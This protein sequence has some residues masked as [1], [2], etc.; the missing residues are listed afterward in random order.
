VLA[1]RILGPFEVVDQERPVRLGG[2]K[3][4]AL[5]AI[6]LLRRGEAVPSDRLIDQLWGERPPA[7]AAKTLQGY[8]SHLRK[9]LG[10][11][12]L[13][14]RG[15]GYLLV[16][17]PGQVD[18][19]CFEAM[20]TDAR[21]ALADGDAAGARELLD[22]ALGLWRG[23]PLA[24]LAYEPFAQGEVARLKEARLAALEDR[25]DSDL[26]LGD[27]RTLVGE[28]EG[29]VRLHPYRER[30]RGQLMLALYR[31]GRQ[32]DALDTY[33]RGRQALSHDLGLEPG[34]EL[35]A[36]EQRILIHDT[37]LETPTAT[38][39]GRRSTERARGGRGR[40]LIAA[41]GALLVAAAVAAGIVELTHG[42]GIGLR[43]VANSLAA[44]D[45]HSDR[46]T[47]AVPV[48][49]RPGAV[50]FGSGSL[51]VA[52][53]DDQ[54]VSRIDPLTLRTLRTIP[55]V[56]PPT[57][58]AASAGGV[59]VVESNLNP[60][61]SPGTSSVLVGRVEPEFNTLG[62]PVQIGNVVPSGPGA[63]AAQGNSVWVAPST[64]LLTHLNA[65]TGEVGPQLNPNASPAGIALGDG[66]IWLTDTEAN[67][68]VRVDS[69]GLPTPIAV[70]NAP[71]GI[72]VGAGGVWVVDSLDDKVVR[73]DPG[74]RSV[75]AMIAVGRSPAGVA[76][77]AGSVWVAN[78]GDGTVTRINPSTDKAIA[79]IA[80][81]GSPQAVTIA[82]GK[83]W[84]AVDAQSIAPT[85]VGS[86]G[87]TLRIV[88][89]A[90]VD[91]MDPALAAAPLSDQL[92]YATC[93]QL[94]NYPD[95]AGLAGSQL[96][97]EVAQSLP[98]PSAGGR[99]YTFR[100]RRGF[101]FSPPS[102]QPVTAQTFKD[103]I[104]RTLNPGMHSPWAHFLAD[105]VGARAYMAG[106]ASH[107]TGVVANRDTLTI[108]LL[109]PAPDFLS[110]LALPAFCAVPSN[111]PIN[112]NGVRVIPSAGP[113]YVTS[114]TPGQGVV[115]MRNPN[116][117]GSRPHHFARIELAVGISTQRAVAEIEAGSADYTALGLVSP[118]STTITTLA[119]QLAAR[120]GPGSAAATRGGQRYFVDPS[121]QLD[122][123]VLNTHRPLFSDVRMRQAVN[124]AINRR[125]LAQRGDYFQPLPERPAD[126]YLP[127]G[128]PGYR[129]AHIYPTTPDVAK[130]RELAG[131]GGRTAVLYTC[132]VSPCPE[133]AEIVKK[134]L[135][136][137]GLQVQVK[138]FPSDTLF[139]RE[140]TP[141]EPFDLAW[142][143]WIPDYLDPQAM[144]TSILEDSSVGPTFDDR[145]Y[146]RKLTRAARLSGPER[147]LTY[148]KLDLDLARNAA[149]LAA[150]GNLP[151]NDFFSARIGC[152]TYGIDGMDLA[153]LCL[154]DPRR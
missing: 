132:N 143:G 68:V 42:G 133:Q 110:R 113:Y 96:T 23:E 72:T 154:R 98:A 40:A 100:V 48:G 33:R 142:E 82:G 129:D 5:L 152:Q 71:T 124:Y 140:A 53:L 9:A 104:E 50:A 106:K 15:G 34:P 139:A 21:H 114:Y 85:H 13:L 56:G 66:A 24:D 83:A 148:G 134:N 153:S 116:Y 128:M 137:I 138:M 99:T 76:F 89:A 149:P 30:L 109:A 20:V 75:T 127:P 92:L 25:I 43:A 16:A 67:N 10:N 32:A 27:H 2:P 102:D 11:E 41:G 118:A 46:V 31:N 91:F 80:V 123:F 146:Q 22:S 105:V 95:K 144:L 37:A 73:I 59:W 151:G 130:A 60:D 122:Y 86:G 112:R 150:F 62:P 38:A 81:G 6:V 55:V 70:G 58:I 93:A 90:D 14:T 36:L 78:S 51:W 117:H 135:A 145:R 49:A 69:T 107:I 94:V 120:Y 74:T 19:E 7:T 26:A 79:T 61:V 125:A 64:G 136:A 44:I 101:R 47:G 147:Y 115:L 88:S 63:I 57:G 1:F 39:P 103:S 131:G 87:G 121:L 29:L 8:V 126:H 65:T 54:T 141:G 111:T 77:G 108:R 45:T 119:S 84:V 4:R 12:V 35:R 3:Q 17:S 18:A 97:P 52:N 28:L